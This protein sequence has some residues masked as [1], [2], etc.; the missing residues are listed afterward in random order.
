MPLTVEPATAVIW[1]RASDNLM[2]AGGTE[3]AM[4][5]SSWF[6]AA[7]L[8]IGWGPIA[9]SAGYRQSISD[10]VVVS[11]GVVDLGSGDGA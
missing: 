11:D 10:R 5:G 9:L 3:R 7:E 6:A 2:S 1:L 4:A 8:G